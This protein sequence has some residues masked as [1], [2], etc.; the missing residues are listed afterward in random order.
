MQ[1]YAIIGIIILAII[2]GI[3]YKYY[4]L[5]NEISDLQ[6]ELTKSVNDSNNLRLEVALEQSNNKKLKESISSLNED[7]K[8]VTLDKETIKKNFE[9]YKKLPLKD[10]VTN[11]ELK[12][13][14]NSSSEYKN[15]CEYGIELNKKISG[16]KY[17]EF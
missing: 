11:E 4:S 10:K 15:S 2:S 3:G 6:T 8:K 14:L 16:L 5:T 9:K 13:L 1:Q 7:L 12:K 17:D